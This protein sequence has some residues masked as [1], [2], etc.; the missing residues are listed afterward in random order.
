[1]PD[2]AAARHAAALEAEVKRAAEE[3]ERAKEAE[4]KAKKAEAKAKEAEAKA[5]DEAKRRAQEETKRKVD[6]EARK[7]AQEEAKRARDQAKRAKDEAKKAKAEAKRAKDE[8]A[9]TAALAKKQVAAAVKAGATRGAAK[10]SKSTRRPRSFAALLV[11]LGALGMIVYGGYWIATRPTAPE[12]PRDANTT[13]SP[14]GTPSR[15]PA[16]RRRPRPR[17]PFAA[18]VPA[19]LARLR[20]RIARGEKPSRRDYSVAVAYSRDNPSDPRG[21]LVLAHT[22]ADRH[23]WSDS[24]ERYRAAYARDPSSRGDPAMLSDLLKIA[25]TD[26]LHADGAAAIVEMYGAEALPAVRRTLGRAEGAEHDRLETLRR[27]LEIDSAA[28]PAH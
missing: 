2:P 24:L 28:R 12:A 27:Q 14:P 19:E 6:A 1:V 20:R 22:F 7:R 10:R 16:A 26:S 23:W 25:V 21:D 8:A 5:K 13:A 18:G 15:P 4:A 11:G 3:A 9:K 17:D